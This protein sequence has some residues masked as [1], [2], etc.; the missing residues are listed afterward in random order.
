MHPCTLQLT[1][2]HS[3]NIVTRQ[4][5]GEQSWEKTAVTAGRQRSTMQPLLIGG[6]V[7]VAFA[8][9]VKNLLALCFQNLETRSCTQMKT[10]VEAG[11]SEPFCGDQHLRDS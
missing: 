6:V 8:M 7:L 10:L 4:S 11:R 5:N 3:S 9:Q 2:T 1:H